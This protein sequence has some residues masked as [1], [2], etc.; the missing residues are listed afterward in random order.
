MDSRER[1][2]EIIRTEYTDLIDG[3][4][5]KEL[6]DAVSEG[7]TDYYYEQYQRFRKEHPK[8]IERYSSFQLKDLNH[9]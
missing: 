6:I 4:V 7:V 3:K 8:S 5:D 2:L 9:P 1:F